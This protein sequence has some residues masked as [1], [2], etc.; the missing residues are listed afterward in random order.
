VER[1]HPDFTLRGLS[2]C[3]AEMKVLLPPDARR[4]DGDAGLQGVEAILGQVVERES[5]EASAILVSNFL[6]EDG[7]A[8]AAAREEVLARQQ[9]QRAALD[10]Q[11]V[12]SRLEQ[13]RAETARLA[14]PMSQD[15]D[16]LAGWSR[17]IETER[18]APAATCV[19]L[20]RA[21]P[22]L[23]PVRDDAGAAF[24]ARGGRQKTWARGY[25][26]G[27]R[28]TRG[29]EA[30]RILPTCTPGNTAAPLSGSR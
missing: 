18:A 11:A 8:Y 17:G 13:W 23:A 2:P 21:D 24:A 19:E 5:D 10:T 14:R 4:G 28:L 15:P 22:S 29:Q 12:A 27:V 3:R 1:E 25:E 6:P 7:P 26:D 20:L 30:L 9:E 16:Y